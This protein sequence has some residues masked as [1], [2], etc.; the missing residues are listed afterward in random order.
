MYWGYEPSAL[1]LYYATGGTSAL[2][3]GTMTGIGHPRTY[4]PGVVP[5]LVPTFGQAEK[6]AIHNI[7]GSGQW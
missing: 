5:S 2:N 3:V 1:M 4:V 6:L 7:I